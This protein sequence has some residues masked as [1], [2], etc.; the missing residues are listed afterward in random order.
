MKCECVLVTHVY[1]RTP[2]HHTYMCTQT[3]PHTTQALKKSHSADT[4]QPLLQLRQ[5]WPVPDRPILPLLSSNLPKQ[6]LSR[7]RAGTFAAAGRHA[8]PCRPRPPGLTWPGLAWA[9]QPGPASLGG[10]PRRNGRGRR[11]R[12]AARARRPPW[13][14][15][16]RRGP[17]GGGWTARRSPPRRGP[18]G[19]RGPC[20]APQSVA[21]RGGCQPAGSELR[22]R[23][24]CVEVRV[25]AVAHVR[26][27]WGG[28]SMPGCAQT[29][30]RVVHAMH[31]CV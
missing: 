9:G 14:G 13:R 28:R 25:S 10:W 17:R 16:R 8:V 22:P 31:M 7:G 5:P 21:G 4:T 6:Q 27:G 30:S 23:A 3:R 26:T 12:P 15:C 20:R 1:E 24:K 2:T 18:G 19:R 11:R 29:H